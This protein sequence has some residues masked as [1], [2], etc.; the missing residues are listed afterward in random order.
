M[1]NVIK[2]LSEAFLLCV[3]L[4]CPSCAQ[5]VTIPAGAEPI[6]AEV[7]EE[8]RA[9]WA[10]QGLPAPEGERCAAP[11]WVRVSFEEFR[12]QCPRSSCAEPG[13][14][15]ETCAHAC[16]E[17]LSDTIKVA[18][19]AGEVPQEGRAFVR[20]EPEAVL[21]AHETYHVWADCT[22]G[23]MDAEHTHA[24]I[25]SAHGALAAVH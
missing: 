5:P 6:L 22:L 18:Y 25:W 1:R 17:W 4:L 15:P 11:L 13:A 19:F 24:E 10:A 3:A 14:R 21:Q 2:G 8:A 12:D 7:L 9:A 16:T 20:W 23:D